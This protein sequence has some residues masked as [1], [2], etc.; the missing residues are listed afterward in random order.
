MRAL[1][2]VCAVLGLFV[3]FLA[4]TQPVSADQAVVAFVTANSL[5]PTSPPSEPFAIVTIENESIDS[6]LAAVITVVPDSAIVT[7]NDPAEAC[8]VQRVSVFNTQITRADYHGMS[9][10]Y[11]HAPSGVLPLVHL[12]V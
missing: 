7:A 2:V 10:V 11:D 4:P 8:L 1:W 6:G 3:L 12:R 5:G 9:P